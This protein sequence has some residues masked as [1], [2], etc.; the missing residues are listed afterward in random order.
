SYFL[1][2][3][4]A[5]GEYKITPKWTLQAGYG[6]SQRPPTLTEL[7]AG[8]AFLGLIQNG[9]N[10]I[11]GNPSLRKEEMHQINV[12][13]NGK[14]DAVR[15]GGN[16]FYA[17]LPNYI[18]YQPLGPFTVNSAIGVGVTPIQQLRF[19]NTPL[20]TLFGFDAYS[21]ADVTPWLTPF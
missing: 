19:I 7:Y 20:A 6:H 14:Y 10:S 12:G 17:F 13:L 9:L 5:T 1:F 3:A 15:V 4:F 8:G 11:Y 18:T 21:E 2:S 16:A